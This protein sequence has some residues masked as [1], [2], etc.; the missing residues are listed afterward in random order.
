MISEVNDRTASYSRF[1]SNRVDYIQKCIVTFGHTPVS[2][3]EAEKDLRSV[4]Y[5]LMVVGSKII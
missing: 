1:D 2:K 4:K 5:N 3:T